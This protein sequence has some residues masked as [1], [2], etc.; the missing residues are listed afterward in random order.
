M[1]VDD[2]I[3]QTIG[4]EGGFVND[5]DDPGGATK[6]GITIGTLRAVRGR[7]TVQDVRDLTRDEAV[8]IYRDR[9]FYRPRID[10]LPIAMQPTVFDMYVNAG[11]NAIKILQRLLSEFNEQVS[12]DGALGPQTISA[13]ERAYRRA[14]EFLVDAYGIARRNY[15]FRIAD[16]RPQSRKY[17]RRRDGGKGG[18]ITRSEQFISSRWHLTAAEFQRRVQAWG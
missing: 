5:P 8:E 1:N 13:T 7:A 4:H 12:V 6:Y 16:R 2:I 15:Y 18:W 17:A 9:Y 3:D 11:G 10:E 14:G